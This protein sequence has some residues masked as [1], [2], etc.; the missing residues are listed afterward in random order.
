MPADSCSLRP[1]LLCV[2]AGA[3]RSLHLCDSK[4]YSTGPSAEP[5]VPILRSF[6]KTEYKTR[7]RACVSESPR[8]DTN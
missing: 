8:P 4:G 6:L 1:T 7:H 3:L 2:Y 5:P